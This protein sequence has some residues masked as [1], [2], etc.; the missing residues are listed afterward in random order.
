VGPDGPLRDRPYCHGTAVADGDTV[1][2]IGYTGDAQYL[3][4]FEPS[5]GCAT[6]FPIPSRG[7]LRA[8]AAHPTG[9]RAFVIDSEVYLTRAGSPPLA[10]IG[11][12]ALVRGFAWR[13]DVLELVEP[14]LV[15]SWTGKDWT[16]RQ[17]A[18]PA[19]E[20]VAQVLEIAWVEGGAWRYL[21]SRAP[22]RADA[23]GSVRVDLLEGDEEGPPTAV[24]TLEVAPPHAQHFDTGEVWVDLPL[25]RSA[26]GVVGYP[27]A[28]ATF[29]R[30]AT[31][32]E[33][34]RLS[35]TTS[36]MALVEY[37]YEVVGGS[38]RPIL[39]VSAAGPRSV[40][41]RDRW[42]QLTPDAY[43]S[44]ADVGG[45]AGPPLTH[46]FWLNP[47]FKVLPSRSGGYWVMGSL[48]EVFLHVDGSLCRTDPLNS[49]ERVGR[50]FRDDRS[51]RNADFYLE[52]ATLKRAAVPF[53]LL[54]F[55]LVVVPAALVVRAR[56]AR[57]SGSSLRW[58]AAAYIAGCL[59]SFWPFFQLTGRFHS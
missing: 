14:A 23:P 34:T 39:A 52:F 5:L 47:G 18:A 24:G 11:A 50:L 28:Q 21:F 22:T 37:D 59:L 25:D 31:G 43:P 46:S 42:L 51:K 30:T 33:P 6:A 53:V 15:R 2:Q 9:D 56:G 13:G 16:T 57:G 20:G 54:F 29:E 1:W 8:F 45:A 3:L 12:A 27:T 40:R 41:V 55:P 10:Q 32:W 49:L 19:S 26:G 38:L 36:G 35:A 17:I 48:G 7:S 44:L 58:L 4:R